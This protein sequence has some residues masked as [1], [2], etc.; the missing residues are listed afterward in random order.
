MAVVVLPSEAW[1][2]TLPSGW[3]VAVRSDAPTPANSFVVT[4]QVTSG[5]RL[6]GVQFTKT[7][8][9]LQLKCLSDTYTGYEPDAAQLGYL[10]YANYFPAYTAP[11]GLT[12][13]GRSGLWSGTQNSGEIRCQASE[14]VIGMFVSDT[15]GQMFVSTVIPATSTC[16]TSYESAR[17]SYVGTSLKVRFTWKGAKPSA[18]WDL[19]VPGSSSSPS[20]SGQLHVAPVVIGG[21][22]EYG[23][24]VT[25]TLSGVTSG[26]TGFRVQKTGD[27]GCY[28]TGTTSAVAV[29]GSPVDGGDLG[30]GDC[31]LNPFC[32]IKAALVWAFVPSSDS[33]AGLTDRWED[34]Q[35]EV[36]VSYMVGGFG[37]I[38]AVLD[39]TACEDNGT[40]DA[41]CADMGTVDDL[42]T[43]MDSLGEE[44][45][46]DLLGA[47]ASLESTPMGAGIHAGLVIMLWGGFVWFA[48]S[49]IS[50]S[51]GGRE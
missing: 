33:A 35:T 42:P 7:G 26:T 31:G 2:Y 19:Y 16:P 44:A 30:D 28:V 23:A 9:S 49:R 5:G 36:P 21:P 1:A 10:H 3:T 40:L 46:V 25:V 32:Y 45:S 4:G 50:R 20:G 37:L 14:H 13:T 29:D 12:I 11:G 24:E 48:W 51:F 18:G 27:S 39:A 8:G 43:D 38:R 41:T 17:A 34:L 22:G 47:A 6:I 15:A